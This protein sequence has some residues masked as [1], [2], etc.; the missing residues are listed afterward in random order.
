MPSPLCEIYF[1]LCHP[2]DHKE[3]PV[4]GSE[5]IKYL[6]QHYDPGAWHPVIQGLQSGHEK[7]SRNANTK[8]LWL[9]LSIHI[10]NQLTAY[11]LQHINS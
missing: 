7:I 11:R 4:E 9:A 10:K 6:H 1:G 8:L 3:Y 5:M 2:K